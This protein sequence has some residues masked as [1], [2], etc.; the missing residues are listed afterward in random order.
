MLDPAL[1]KAILERVAAIPI[2]DTLGMQ[3]LEL[4]PGLCRIKV[5]RK[6]AYDGVF[7]SFHG[8]LLM[9]VADS[10]ACFAI[11]TQTGSQ[12]R[13]TTTDMNIRF[14][15]P[16]LSDL[17]VAA[18]TIKVGRTMCPVGVELFDEAGTLVAVA[19]VNYLLLA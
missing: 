5:A 10:A 14:L 16:C 19:Q 7:E 18:R 1:E 17:T 11:L 12:A 2:V 3:V 6:P 15:A 9:T 13:L 4:A 8:G